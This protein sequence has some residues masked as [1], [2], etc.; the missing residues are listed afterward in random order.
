MHA[1]GGVRRWRSL[2]RT[3]RGAHHACGWLGAPAGPRKDPTSPGRCESTDGW[4]HTGCSG[5]HGDGNC[6]THAHRRRSHMLLLHRQAWPRGPWCWRLYGR[7][8]E[9]TAGVGLAVSNVRAGGPSTAVVAGDLSGCCRL[10]RCLAPLLPTRLPPSHAPGRPLVAAGRM[11]FG[12]P[13]DWRLMT[14][15][16]VRS[17]RLHSRPVA[18]AAGAQYC[19]G[20]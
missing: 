15:V 18:R 7:G 12:H 6:K 2:S 16:V 17:C 13:V 3:Q 11:M 5:R 19:H 8:V 1:V 4:P 14:S 20:W 9:A 10:R